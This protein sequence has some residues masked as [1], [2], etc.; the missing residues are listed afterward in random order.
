MRL[1]V[2]VALQESEKKTGGSATERERER[3][4]I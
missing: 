1:E 2:M 3:E 4:D